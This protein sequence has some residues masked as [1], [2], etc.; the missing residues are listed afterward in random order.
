MKHNISIIDFCQKLGGSRLS[1]PM[2]SAL[3]HYNE[4]CICQEE[5]NLD[6]AIRCYRSAVKNDPTHIDANYN[7]AR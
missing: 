6:E 3:K 1:L 4:G 5:G 7:L 2:K